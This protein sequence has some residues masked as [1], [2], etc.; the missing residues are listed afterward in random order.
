LG[1]L[2]DDVTAVNST[3]ITMAHRVKLYLFEPLMTN[4][5]LENVRERLGNKHDRQEQGH[6]ELVEVR[7]GHNRW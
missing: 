1:S 2:V 6:T 7:S 4:D 5:K 3:R